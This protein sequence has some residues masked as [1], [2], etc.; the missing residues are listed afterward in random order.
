MVC[1]QIALIFHFKNI[2]LDDSS[3]EKAIEITA[4]AMLVSW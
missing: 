1:L 4:R 3:S 2:H